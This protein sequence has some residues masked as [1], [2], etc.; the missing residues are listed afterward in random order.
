MKLPHVTSACST[1]WVLLS[2]LGPTLAQDTRLVT[3]HVSVTSPDG[4]FASGLIRDAFEIVVDGQIG[5]IERVETLQPGMAIVVLVDI[6]AS[7]LPLPPK[8]RSSELP[9]GLQPAEIGRGVE[10][11]ASMLQSGD[12]V[13]VGTVGSRIALDGRFTADKNDLAAMARAVVSP[14]DIDRHGPSPIW[15]AVHA[16]VAMLADQ[17]GARAIVLITDGRATGNRHSVVQAAEAAAQANVT[18]SIVSLA[19]ARE[20]PRGNMTD[21]VQPTAL[22]RQ[23]ADFTGGMLEPYRATERHAPPITPFIE[24]AFRHLR[25]RYALTFR[26]PADGKA[27]QVQVRVPNSGLKATTRAVIGSS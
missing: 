20:N 3:V 7:M 25:E 11:I 14:A 18:T 16:A 24:R 8:L 13:L 5:Q 22:L 21:I 2:A 23:L 10:R 9:I 15:D 26:A 12:R 1:F 19:T 6:S 4:A 27:H 17:T